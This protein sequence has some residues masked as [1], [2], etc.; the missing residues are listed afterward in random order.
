MKSEWQN[1]PALEENA[2]GQSVAS[3]GKSLKI[4]QC[5]KSSL[6]CQPLPSLFPWL[7]CLMTLH[8]AASP[9]REEDA[10][11]SGRATIAPIKLT[12]WPWKKS[13]LSQTLPEDSSLQLP[14]EK[15]PHGALKLSWSRPPGYLYQNDTATA[16]AQVCA[17]AAILLHRHQFCTAEMQA[18]CFK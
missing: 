7:I 13:H 11:L 8:R 16:Q 17:D 1:C 4:K 10:L 9:P 14:F 12:S 5:P 2:T 15:V 6:T 18:L 3:Q